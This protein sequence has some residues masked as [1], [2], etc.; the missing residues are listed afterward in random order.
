MTKQGRGRIKNR[1][2]AKTGDLMGNMLS[3]LA[4][5]SPGTACRAE[6]LDREPRRC[7]LADRGC[8]ACC[9]VCDA[10]PRLCVACVDRPRLSD[11]HSHQAP[12]AVD[13]AAP[14]QEDISCHATTPRELDRETTRLGKLPCHRVPVW[15]EHCRLQNGGRCNHVQERPGESEAGAFCKESPSWFEGRV[16]RTSAGS[17]ITHQRHGAGDREAVWTDLAILGGWTSAKS[18]SCWLHLGEL[19]ALKPMPLVQESQGTPARHICHLR[20]S[21]LQ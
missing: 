13:R 17:T 8:G 9:S 16:S 1:G 12:S 20:D 21:R 3:D 11:M 5:L 14:V 7:G 4:E 10:L 18:A 15:T 6:V 19:A 2:S